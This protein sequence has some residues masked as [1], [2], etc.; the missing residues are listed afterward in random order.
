MVAEGV[1]LVAIEDAFSMGL[2]NITNLRPMI[3]EFG[4]A[5]RAFAS[6]EINPLPETQNWL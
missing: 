6:F 1:A 5:A 2:E 4:E 3:S